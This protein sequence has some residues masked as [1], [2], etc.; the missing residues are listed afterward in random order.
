MIDNGRH[1]RSGNDKLSDIDAKTIEQY[2]VDPHTRV[3]INYNNEAGPWWHSIEVV[4]SGG[5]WLDS[6]DSEKKAVSYIEENKLTRVKSNHSKTC[7][8][9]GG[10][11]FWLM[12]GKL[13]CSGC[14]VTW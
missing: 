5:F 12:K 11:C 6:F 8:R 10:A 4:N 7:P 2:I 9:C 14:W 1:Y 3:F 13:E